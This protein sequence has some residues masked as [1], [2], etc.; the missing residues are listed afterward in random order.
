MAYTPLYTT[1]LYVAGQSH[2]ITDETAIPDEVMESGEALVTGELLRNSKFTLE[3]ISYSDF[4]LKQAATFAILYRIQTTGVMRGY[5]GQTGQIITKGAGGTQ[6]IMAT[7]D[8]GGSQFV[9]Q[10][11]DRNTP[12]P[13]NWNE[14][15][16][17]LKL[18]LQDPTNEGKR[19]DEVSMRV[20]NLTEQ[21][22]KDLEIRKRRGQS[23][24]SIWDT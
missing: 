1:K 19:I 9:P 16:Y 2:V 23:T 20:A 14:W 22:V 12:T 17:W 8:I 4:R 21:R 11:V 13:N 3:N 10:E 6:T 15:Q 18:Y 7:A 24:N 5:F